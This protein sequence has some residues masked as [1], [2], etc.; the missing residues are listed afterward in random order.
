MYNI[1]TVE[2]GVEAMEAIR[3]FKNEGFEEKNI[4]LFAHDRERSS[5]LTSKTSTER[6]GIK[7]QGIFETIGNSFKSRGDELR[8]K[9]RAV[10]M[11]QMEAERYEEVL[12]KGKI[13]LVA[14]DEASDMNFTK[15][16]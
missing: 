2:N 3:S 15:H 5:D 1:R 8:S 11:D 14:S 16:L 13:V 6:I 7:E 12:D 9:M 4:Y 10:G